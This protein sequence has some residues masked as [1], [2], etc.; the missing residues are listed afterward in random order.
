MPRRRRIAEAQERPLEPLLLGGA[1]QAADPP[2][3]GKAAEDVAGHRKRLRQRLMEAGAEAFEDYE[4][5][6]LLLFGVLPRVDTKPIAKALLRE[7]KDLPGVLA[8]S[9]QE[10]K[11]VP[12]CAEAVIAALKAN[13]AVAQ[14][15]TRVTMRKTQVLSSFQAV[16]DYCQASM[17]LETREQFR[18]IFLDIRNQV[19]RDERQQ[20]GTVDH[21]PVYPREVVKRALELD[22]SAL[23]MVHNHPSGDP[24]PSRPD[25]EM[26]RKVRDAL[27]SVGITL[28]DHLIIARGGHLSFRSE[29]LL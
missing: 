17:A 2:K 27:A 25:I 20:S 3:P 10:L 19:I 8:A 18:L 12:G 5:L 14:R 15:M 13:Q 6:E 9:P 16:L 11:N 4:L 22:A 7:F 1:G 28:H 24:T 29:Q 23:I 26:T 21:A